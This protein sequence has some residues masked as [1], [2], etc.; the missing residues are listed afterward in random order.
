MKPKPLDSATSTRMRA[1]R[2]AGTRPEQQVRA[3]LRMLG[4]RYRLDCRLPG[5]PDVKLVGS[6]VVIF[7]HGCFWHRHPGC[8]RATLPRSNQGWWLKKFA[9]TV[10]RDERV[11]EELKRRKYV[12]V[13]I[14]ECDAANVEQL[15]HVISH[16]LAAVEFR[17]VQRVAEA[18]RQTLN[19]G[20]SRGKSIA[21]N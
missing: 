1:V 10:A 12:V 5:R 21:A 8:S 11:F 6:K 18:L 7:V 15:V 13:T 19:V 14:W 2:R 9:T 20:G 3:V 17:R 16:G 4:L